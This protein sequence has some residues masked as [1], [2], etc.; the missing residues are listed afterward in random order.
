MEGAAVIYKGLRVRGAAHTGPVHATPGS[1]V[2]NYVYEGQVVD[3]T[4]K[5]G[6]PFPLFPPLPP[7]PSLPPLPPLPSL[8]LSFLLPSQK[9][10]L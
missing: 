6:M 9:T 10:N 2:E 1:Q 3:L 4:V 5:L 7:L 8:P